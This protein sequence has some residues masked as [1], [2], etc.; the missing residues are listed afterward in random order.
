M[1]GWLGDHMEEVPLSIRC[2]HND[3]GNDIRA[4]FGSSHIP[5]VQ[6]LGPGILSLGPG[7]PHC[8]AT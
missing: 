7:E 2:G 3:K 8:L 1:R 5:T 6:Y 4:S